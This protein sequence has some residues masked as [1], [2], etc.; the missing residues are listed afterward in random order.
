MW[1]TEIMKKVKLSELL[2]FWKEQY[3]NLYLDDA[4]KKQILYKIWV[5]KKRLIFNRIVYYIP[6]AIVFIFFLIFG[7][8]FFGNLFLKKYKNFSLWWEKVQKKDEVVNYNWFFGPI[9]NVASEVPRSA[10]VSED[11]Y[12]EK[13][14]NK[15]NIILVVV[16][17]VLATLGIYFWKRKK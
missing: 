12:E 1:D 6:I 14:S 15:K 7:N 3:K 17:I 11:M 2:S 13:T 16:L 4:V 8:L 9:S 5:K 10:V